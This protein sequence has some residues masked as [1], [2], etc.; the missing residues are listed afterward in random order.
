MFLVGLHL[1]IKGQSFL[2]DVVT[3]MANV[4][5]VVLDLDM[6]E[7]YVELY[8]SEFMAVKCGGGGSLSTF[9]MRSWWIGLKNLGFTVAKS[10]FALLII[11]RRFSGTHELP[12]NIPCFVCSRGIAVVPVIIIVD[13]DGP[14]SK[15]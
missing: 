5:L 4:T 12:F 6:S 8:S 9:L 1:R 7:D 3:V 11:L 2:P 13:T 15:A 14:C 10:S